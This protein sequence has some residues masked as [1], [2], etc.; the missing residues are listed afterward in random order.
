MLNVVARCHLFG[1]VHRD[2]KPEVSMHNLC[3]AGIHSARASYFTTNIVPV[4]LSPGW[5]QTE[6]TVTEWLDY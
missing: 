2:L 3:S 1:V 5:I 4:L 6:T